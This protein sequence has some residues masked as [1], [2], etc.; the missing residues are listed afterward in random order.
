MSHL[1]LDTTIHL[2]WFGPD[3]VEA[4]AIQGLPHTL[5]PG[6]SPLIGIWRLP[7]TSPRRSGKRSGGRMAQPVIRIPKVLLHGRRG[8][9]R[10]GAGFRLGPEALGQRVQGRVLHRDAPFVRHR[11]HFRIGGR[12]GDGEGQLVFQGQAELL[13]AGKASALP[14]GVAPVPVTRILP[15]QHGQLHHPGGGAQPHRPRPPMHQPPPALGGKRGPGGRLL[16]ASVA[17]GAGAS[18]RAPRPPLPVRSRADS[19][20]A[21]TLHSHGLLS[22]RTKEAPF[23]FPRRGG[24]KMRPLRNSGP[25]KRNH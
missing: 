13:V 20:D 6:W 19:R 1:T 11:R 12:G 14:H 3:A 5:R 24:S 25:R 10:L 15:V 23:S 18:I 22:F 4:A 21:L 8:Q 9:G 7:T 17:G 16:P 2:N